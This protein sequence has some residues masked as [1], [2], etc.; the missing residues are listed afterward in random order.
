M[1]QAMPALHYKP[2][3]YIYM[4][5]YVEMILLNIFPYLLFQNREQIVAA[6]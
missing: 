2:F 3:G 5:S 1:S 4:F 6:W